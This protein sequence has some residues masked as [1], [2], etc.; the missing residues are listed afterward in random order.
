MNRNTTGALAIVLS[1]LA[2]FS[3]GCTFIIDPEAVQQIQENEA[4][5]QGK[6]TPYE[7]EQRR[8]ARRQDKLLEQMRQSM[9]T[10]LN[11][12]S[13][14]SYVCRIISEDAVKCDPQQRR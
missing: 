5:A 10:E 14:V 7:V 11:Q 4:I 13:N 3:T 1:L 2:C 6:L 8:R 9:Q 12:R